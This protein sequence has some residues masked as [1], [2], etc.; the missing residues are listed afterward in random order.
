[1]AKHKRNSPRQRRQQT[2]A[3]AMRHAASLS[4]NIQ[5]C[6]TPDRI[7]ALKQSDIKRL[8][9]IQL[10]ADRAIGSMI[11]AMWEGKP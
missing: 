5:K 7:E 9:A 10:A 6:L 1:M 4:V 8:Y 3:Y 11:A 2:L